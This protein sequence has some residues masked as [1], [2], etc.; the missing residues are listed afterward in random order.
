MMEK[1]I[2]SRC[3]CVC[4][5]VYTLSHFLYSRNWHN[6]VNQLY[7]N[8]EKEDVV[9][10]CHRVLL[11]HKKGMS[12]CHL[13]KCGWAYRVLMLSK[14]TEIGNGKYCLKL[15]KPEDETYST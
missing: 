10:I 5:C 13:Q 3:V 4:V 15:I 14:I 9:F 7:F 6:I 12:F 11:S 2:K 8:F 1:N